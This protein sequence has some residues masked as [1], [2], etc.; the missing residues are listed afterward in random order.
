LNQ[1]GLIHIKGILCFR[2]VFMGQNLIS[3][4]FKKV[5]NYEKI[6]EGG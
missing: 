5:E 6:E 4:C 3:K 1:V 2:N